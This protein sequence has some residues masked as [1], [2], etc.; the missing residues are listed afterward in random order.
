MLVQEANEAPRQRMCDLDLNGIGLD[1]DG[2][3]AFV[4]VPRDGFFEPKLGFA[5]FFVERPGLA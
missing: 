4:R 5:E 1:G 2:G 3:L